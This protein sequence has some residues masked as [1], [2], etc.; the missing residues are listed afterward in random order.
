MTHNCAEGCEGNCRHVWEIE[1]HYDSNFDVL[2]VDDMDAWDEIIRA[3]E[4]VYDNMAAGEERTLTIRFNGPRPEKETVT[5][6][7][8]SIV[9]AFKRS[10]RRVEHL[11]TCLNYRKP[12]QPHADTCSRRIYNGQE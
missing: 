9:E 2:V 11:C 8:A 7:E 3:L 1:P 4:A 12:G 6:P 5:A 10:P